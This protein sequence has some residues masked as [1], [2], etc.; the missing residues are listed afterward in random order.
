LIQA[1]LN[2]FAFIGRYAS[3]TLP[4]GVLIG[5]AMPFMAEWMQPLM[6]AGLI[7]PLTL[8]LVRIP[9]HQMSTSLKRWKAVAMLSIWMLWVSPLLVYLALQLVRLP[10]PISMA[11]V[12]TA[13]A[14][15][16]TACAAIAVFLQL[17]A[18]LVVVTT[19]TTMLLVPL[20]LPPVLHY[21]VGL[22]VNVQLWQ[23]SLRLAGY[24]LSGFV[25]ALIIKRV[26]GQVRIDRHAS[27]FDGISVVFISIFIIGLMDG[28]TALALQKS[29]FVF[30]TLVAATLLVLG[31]YLLTTVMFWRLGAR[32]A[33]AV[34]LAS[35]NCNMGLMYLVFTDQATIDF[36]V[37][38]AI[39][40][41]PMFFLPSLLTPLVMRLDSR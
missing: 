32:S 12:I 25:S 7:I 23:L 13:A 6:P 9:L 22:E 26:M 30:Q 19:I 38:F 40:Q 37:F 11:S 27:L 18:A 4:A 31:L 20:T 17:D 14:P 1:V 24:I 29:W 2:V 5:L 33:M 39:G 15:P 21:L 35:G 8:S 3:Y 28:V 10:E 36:L 16:I 41:I 34:G